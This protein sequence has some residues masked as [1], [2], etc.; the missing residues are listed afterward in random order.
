MHQHLSGSHPVL[1]GYATSLL[2]R[3]LNVA[4][5]SHSWLQIETQLK[6]IQHEAQKLCNDSS[7]AA[8][9]HVRVELL[10]QFLQVSNEQAEL[11][12][13]LKQDWL[14]RKLSEGVARREVVSLKAQLFERTGTL[15]LACA[16]MHNDKERHQNELKGL[17]SF[18]LE[19]MKQAHHLSSTRLEAAIREGA[20]HDAKAKEALAALERSNLRVVE[21]ENSQKESI[22]TIESLQVSLRNVSIEMEEDKE[23]GRWWEQEMLQSQEMLSNMR[24]ERQT[25]IVEHQSALQMEKQ[26]VLQVETQLASVRS[27]AKATEDEY[28]LSRR[29]LALSLVLSRENLKDAHAIAR[30]QA[31]A[32][33]QRL[34]TAEEQFKATEANLCNRVSS[35]GTSVRQLKYEV[36]GLRQQLSSSEE[37]G[38]RTKVL[39]GTKISFLS[40]LMLTSIFSERSRRS[41]KPAFYLAEANKRNDGEPWYVYLFF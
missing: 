34:S 19:Q 29:E 9:P 6:K 35:L 32:L 12:Q 21:L 3:E 17:R 36:D 40:C 22:A 25:E 7:S 26:R 41:S 38:K 13:V 30:Q 16:Q 37:E 8:A 39:H 1:A 2:H 27:D 10:R 33:R 24:K 4:G 11:Y 5:L 18:H 31:D 23:I 15:E 14:E 28:V 20:D